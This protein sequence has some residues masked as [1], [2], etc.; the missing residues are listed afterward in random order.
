MVG[1]LVF[2]GAGQ[3]ILRVWM[4]DFCTLV[5]VRKTNVGSA[6]FPVVATRKHNATTEYSV[7]FA[8]ASRL[9][10]SWRS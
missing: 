8:V 2:G 6:D 7:N 10:E 3:K 4:R 1:V 9:W 5:V